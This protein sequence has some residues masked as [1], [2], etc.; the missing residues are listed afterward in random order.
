MRDTVSLKCAPH[1]CGDVAIL[2]SY[3]N[4]CKRLWSYPTQ[5]FWIIEFT[6]QFVPMAY[7]RNSYSCNLLKFA[8]V[9]EV[10]KARLPEDV[11]AGGKQ[12]V[13]VGTLR[14]SLLRLDQ[15]II[16]FAS[17]T[18]EL[19]PKGNNGD[20]IASDVRR[21]TP[22]ASV[23]GGTNGVETHVFYLDTDNNLRV[24]VHAT[25]T[26]T[27]T[28]S[29]PLPATD[30]A[31]GDTNLAAVTWGKRNDCIK[32]YYQQ[33]SGDLKLLWLSDGQWFASG[34]GVLMDPRRGTKL[35]YVNAIEPYHDSYSFHLFYIAELKNLHKIIHQSDIE[36]SDI[37]REVLT[38]E[39]RIAW[40]G[41]AAGEYNL[42]LYFA[43]PDGEKATKP[44]GTTSSLS[45]PLAAVTFSN[46]NGQNVQVLVKDG[47]SGLVD[48]FATGVAK[49]EK[50]DEPEVPKD[51]MMHMRMLKLERG[52]EEFFYATST[53]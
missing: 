5:L 25:G 49:G 40:P 44:S 23:I 45:K 24:V 39:V 48:M 26:S 19:Q 16:L 11:V 42:R 12:E 50:W 17:D 27:W 47:S 18:L 32:V 14:H 15:L 43:N 34:G 9:E 28:V 36:G 7:G 22:L 3:A 33:T 41:P 29:D 35:A 52:T 31:S 2:T 6:L 38:P 10:D 37:D 20:P 21:D 51:Y 8:C 13:C 1:V 53:P 4:N 46:D 30:I